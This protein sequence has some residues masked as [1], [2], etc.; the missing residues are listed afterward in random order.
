MRARAR[1]MVGAGLL[2]APLSCGDLA[3]Q[4]ESAEAAGKLGEK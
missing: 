2:L 4:E 1:L 3:A